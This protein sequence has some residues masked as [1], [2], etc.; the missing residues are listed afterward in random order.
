MTAIALGCSHTAGVGVDPADRFTAVLGQLLN[1]PI[2][3]LAVPGGNASDVQTNLI[4][5]LKTQ[6]PNFVIAQWPNPVRLTVWHEAAAHRENTNTASP[7]FDQLLKQSV[8]NFYQPW[9]LAIVTCDLLCQQIAVPIIHIM[10]EQLDSQH[11]QQLIAQGITLHQDQKQ[12]GKTWLFDSAA[13]DRL[14]HS[15]ACHKQWAER[16]HGLT[17]AYTTP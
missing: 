16:L 15:A 5:E 9:I 10:L 4:A 3:N 11:N 17:N 14:H 6:R 13:S 2:K 1:Q 12:P 8:E 7:A